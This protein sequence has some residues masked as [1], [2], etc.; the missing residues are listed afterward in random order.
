MKLFI[1]LS[2]LLD[3]GEIT[4]S[5]FERFINLSEKHIPNSDSDLLQGIGW[6]A[7]NY[8][9]IMLFQLSNPSGLA[10]KYVVP[11]EGIINV[12][13]G[14]YFV[15]LQT[16]RILF[17]TSCFVFGAILIVLSTLGWISGP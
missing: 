10:A 3:K 11:F 6:I 4:Q 5:E 1:D 16:N 13:L 12:G 2:K 8:G 17:T 14:Y 15:Q 9:F 7:V